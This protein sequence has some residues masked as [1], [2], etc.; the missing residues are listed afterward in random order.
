MEIDYRIPFEYIAITVRDVPNGQG[1]FTPRVIESKVR[2]QWKNISFIEEFAMHWM[3]SDDRP[4][5]NIVMVSGATHI[6]LADYKEVASM[7]KKYKIWESQKDIL[8]FNKPN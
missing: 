6:V 4:K 2:N 5:T 1:G 3:F 8:A 7:W